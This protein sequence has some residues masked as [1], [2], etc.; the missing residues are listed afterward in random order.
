MSESKALALMPLGEVREM[1]TVAAKSGLF[2][3]IKTPEAAL[4]LML[5]CQAE[6]LHPVQALRR[7]HIINGRPAM[8]ADAMLAEFQARGGRVE[9]KQNTDA[10]CEGV[11]TAPG[12][13]TPTT[14]R[15]T[16]QDAQTAGVTGNPTWKKYPRQMLRAR[17]ISEAVRMTMPEVIV[18]IY[19]PEEVGDFAPA[20]KADAPV[21]ATYIPPA[22]EKVFPGAKAVNDPKAE[23]TAPAPGATTSTTAPA[24]AADSARYERL[25]LLF[26]LPNN[27]GGEGGLGWKGPKIVPFLKANFGVEKLAALSP[28]QVVECERQVIALMNAP[29]A[30]GAEV[31]S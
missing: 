27:G 18:G 26:T 7:Y 22:V 4:A 16:M 2:P 1:A 29:Q 12:V 21:E 3:D 17:V 14:V 11:F 5:L 31:A 30:N 23:T 24:P 10:I 6:G 8:K 19:T 13:S 20:P 9:W 25:K 15:W 28:E